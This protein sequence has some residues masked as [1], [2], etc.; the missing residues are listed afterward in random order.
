[1]WREGCVEYDRCAGCWVR[2]RGKASYNYDELGLAVM[3]SLSMI[4]KACFQ[5]RLPVS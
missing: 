3:T 5:N 2:Q 4:S 1:M